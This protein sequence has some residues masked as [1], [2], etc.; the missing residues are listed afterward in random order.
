MKEANKTIIGAFVV[1]AV[2]LL[3]FGIAIFGSGVIFGKSDKYVLYFDRS[4]K[5]LSAGSPV[6]FMGVKIGNVS[7]IDLVYDPVLQDELIEVIIDVSLS[8]V[9]GVPEKIGYPDYKNFIKHGLRAKLDTQSFVTGQLMISF[10]FYPDKPA[11]MHNVKEKYPE[12]PT[13]PTPPDIFE[14]MDQVP[15]K[16][17]SDNLSQIVATFNKLMSSQ[18]FAELDIAIKELTATARAMRLLAEY[19][20][21][22]PEAFLKG[23]PANKGE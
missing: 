6:I 20:E 3:I 4:V 8:R 1:G 22:H 19:L 21:A 12:L 7:E 14:V 23:K 11:K 5:G 17:I 2:V 10:G 13:L 9:K 18:T 16:E 15:I